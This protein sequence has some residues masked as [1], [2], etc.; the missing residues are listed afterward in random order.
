MGNPKFPVRLILPLVFAAVSIL[1]ALAGTV[2][3]PSQPLAGHI[4]TAA[5][6]EV[7]VTRKVENSVRTTLRGHVSGA[8][9][10]AQDLGRLDSSTPAE[11]L[12][13]VLQSSDA[14]KAELRRVLG[15]CRG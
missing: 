14:Q 8:L 1:P 15:V 4:H 11:H 10:K 13:M 6:P 2:A 12:V 7:R 9:R 5:S 3:P